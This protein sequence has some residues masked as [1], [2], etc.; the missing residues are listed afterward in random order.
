MDVKDFIPTSEELEFVTTSTPAE[1]WRELFRLRQATWEGFASIEARKGIVKPKVSISSSYGQEVLRIIMFRVLE[2]AA[3]SLLAEDQTHVKEELI[4]AMNYLMSLFLLDPEINPD[5]DYL[6]LGEAFGKMLE[7]VEWDEA[8]TQRE[9]G[10]CT[11]LL[12]GVL[13]DKL[14]N[15]AWMNQA[16]DFYFSGREIFYET[17]L[18][19]A[20]LFLR[21]FSGLRGFV[22]LYIAKDRVLQFRLRSKY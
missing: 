1:I 9:L 7:S 16:Q 19:V 6:F 10:E 13:S 17:L 12:G 11:K 21:P 14:R 18:Q 22:S 4:D 8:F 5:G 15:R 2:E 20:S 3:E